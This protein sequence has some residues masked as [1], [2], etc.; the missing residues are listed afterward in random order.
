MTSISTLSPDSALFVRIL[1]IGGRVRQSFQMVCFRAKN[2]FFLIARFTKFPSHLLHST[3]FNFIRLQFFYTDF[4]SELCRVK[5]VA[6]MA[7]LNS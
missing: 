3:I 6:V 4:T 2:R 1:Q 7:D 5:A